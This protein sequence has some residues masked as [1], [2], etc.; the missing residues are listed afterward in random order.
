MKEESR[1][2]VERVSSSYRNMIR[3]IEFRQLRELSKK[4]WK[5]LRFML[6]VVKRE[7]RTFKSET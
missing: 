6:I 7:T 3:V 5:M 1:K 4:M 2:K